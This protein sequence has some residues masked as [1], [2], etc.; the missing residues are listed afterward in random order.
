VY[1]FNT[2]LANGAFTPNGRFAAFVRGLGPCVA[3]TKSASYLL[4]TQG[5]SNIRN[6]LL[7][8]PV[9]ILQ[10]DSGIPL[11]DFPTDRWSIR[12]FG[13]YTG[14]IDLF[15]EYYQPPLAEAHARESLPLGFGIGYKHSQGQSAML[16]ARRR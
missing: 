12:C 16:L 1:Y 4:H 14:T 8:W 10:D 6:F 2:N 9:A 3:F 7:D 15:K 5:F 11:A 13:N